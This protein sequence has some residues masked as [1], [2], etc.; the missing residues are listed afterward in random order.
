VSLNDAYSKTNQALNQSK[1]TFEQL[2]NDTHLGFSQIVKMLE[3][4]SVECETRS[5]PSLPPI[6]SH[7]QTNASFENIDLHLDKA[8]KDITNSKQRVD[9]LPSFFGEFNE[10]ELN[11][12]VHVNHFFKYNQLD[13]LDSLLE[14]GNLVL[15]DTTN[16]DSVE[17]QEPTSNENK[18]DMAP[19][20]PPPPIEIQSSTPS[21]IVNIFDNKQRNDS[22]NENKDMVPPPPPLKSKPVKRAAT[23]ALFDKENQIPSKKI[24]IE[25]NEK[26]KKLPSKCGE[27]RKTLSSA[28]SLARHMNKVHKKNNMAQVKDEAVDVRVEEEEEVVNPTVVDPVVVPALDAELNVFKCDICTK[29]FTRENT[30]AAHIKSFHWNSNRSASSSVTSSTT[31]SRRSLR[32]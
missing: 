30:F 1:L 17:Q 11:E 9:T 12:N 20:P 16:N 18:K 5:Q 7:S 21:P 3:A 25:L 29:S 23:S 8:L 14:G 2:K 28:R 22:S 4:T 32:H 27:C 24:K 31:Q 6:T 15:W 13:L 10:I 26:V 19:P